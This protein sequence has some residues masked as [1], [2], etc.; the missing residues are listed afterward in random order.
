MRKLLPYGLLIPAALLFGFFVASQFG[1]ELPNGTPSGMLL[2]AAAWSLLFLILHGHR[3]RW[4][5]VRVF[6]VVFVVWKFSA[7]T[8]HH[9]VHALPTGYLLLELGGATV[10][11]WL[12]FGFFWPAASG[13]KPSFPG[14][15][16]VADPGNDRSADPAPERPA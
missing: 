1:Q 11:A 2:G 9:L 7:I 14:C 12:M 4:R 5:S 6:L 15:A 16:E 8:Y 13:R 3:H 10:V